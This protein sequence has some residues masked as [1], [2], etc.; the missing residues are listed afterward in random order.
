[1]QAVILA[2][3]EGQRML[4]LSKS[5]PKGML[6]VANKPV[7][8]HIIA[9]AKKA[10]INEFILVTG[11]KSD[12]LTHYF[13]DGTRFGIK[14]AYCHQE[15]IQGTGAALRAVQ[16]AVRQNFLVF[17]SDML[18]SAAD[19]LQLSQA[20]TI[21]IGVKEKDNPA[22]FGIVEEQN[23]KVSCIV[24]KPDS[25]LSGLVNIGA[26]ILNQHIFT[27]IDKTLLSSRGELELT[28]ALQL[29]I[30][31]GIPICCTALN[32]W[33]DISYPWD[34]LSANTNLLSH[35]VSGSQGIIEEN[36]H[37][38]G[39]CLIGAGSIIRSGSYITGPVIIGE[40]CDIG[41][42]C[43]IRPAT[44]I[45]DNCRIGGSVEIKNSI[46]MRG[47]KIPHMN[48]VGDSIIGEN[49]NLGAGTKIANIRFD[50]KPITISDTNTGLLKFGAVLGDDVQTGIN[51][52]INSGT[53]IG[54]Q[55]NVWPYVVAHGHIPDNV[56]LRKK[57]L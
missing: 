49:C 3:G 30:D 40:N 35:L 27:A 47:S 18:I 22:G 50:K 56:Q 17:N 42:N 6:P 4:P 14:I 2:A 28:Q 11:Y 48:Y 16:D 51:V 34:L 25:A 52:S 39:P 8:E 1:M 31:Q 44:S 41:P 12:V 36:V 54:N 19:I 37:I 5:R 7:I 24:E 29:L 53:L 45:G 23:G 33:Q 9:E 26:Y 21:T 57:P 10:G 38:D 46:I 55:V 32:S 13:G 43:F 15:N 20:E